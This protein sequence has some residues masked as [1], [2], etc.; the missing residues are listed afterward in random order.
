MSNESDWEKFLPLVMFAYCTSV[1]ASTSSSPFELMFG[2]SAHPPPFASSNAY[3]AALHP[4][5][6][7][8]KVSKLYDF[9]KTHMIEVSYHQQNSYNQQ[10]Q[11]RSFQVGDTV[12]LALPTA[13]KLD[14]KQEGGWIVQTVQGPTTY[15]ITDG[16]R[17]RTVHI[18][19]LCK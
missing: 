11:H 17:H 14:S 3:D 4:E 19:R 9:V 1:H 7:C 12:W 16:K 18:N 6:L 5:Q 10:V 2:C 15:V 8:C 13:G